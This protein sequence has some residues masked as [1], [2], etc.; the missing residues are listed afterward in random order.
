MSSTKVDGS[1]EKI[2]FTTCGYG[3]GFERLCMAM[4]CDFKL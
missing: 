1:L 2:T 4:Q 3:N